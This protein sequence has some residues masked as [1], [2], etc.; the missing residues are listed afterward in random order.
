MAWSLVAIEFIA[1]SILDEGDA[2]EQVAAAALGVACQANPFLA[3]S[4]AHREIFDE[5][6]ACKV[7]S[8]WRKI[9]RNAKSLL[10]RAQN[11]KR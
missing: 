6:R 7:L 4:I 2:G 9:S 5:V 10:R 11:Y 1:W 3:W 8:R